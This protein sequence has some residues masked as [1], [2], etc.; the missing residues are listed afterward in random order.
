MALA[1]LRVDTARVATFVD[2]GE[3][4]LHLLEMAELV[5]SVIR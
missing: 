1:R 4:V 3:A 2:K 5:A